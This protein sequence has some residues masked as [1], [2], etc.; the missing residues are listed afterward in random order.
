MALHTPL[1]LGRAVP[2][3]GLG[4]KL[5]LPILGCYFQL[6]NVKVPL[7]F[8]FYG[9]GNPWWDIMKGDGGGQIV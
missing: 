3:T 5:Y 2:C 1:L 8:I 9:Q 4:N 6:K 7:F